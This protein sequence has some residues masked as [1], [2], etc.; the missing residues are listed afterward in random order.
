M[1]PLLHAAALP[2]LVGA[3][4]GARLLPNEK[5]VW[6]RAWCGRG[7]GDRCRAAGVVHGVVC[8][9]TVRGSHPPSKLYTYTLYCM[10]YAG[11]QGYS[12]REA[13]NAT[14]HATRV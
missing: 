11:A 5:Q 4:V 10:H 8:P 12:R 7:R 13:S 6:P 2:Y 1:P 14:M 3:M 9:C